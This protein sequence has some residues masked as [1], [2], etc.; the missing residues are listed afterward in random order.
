MGQYEWKMWAILLILII[1][2]ATIIY[3]IYTMQ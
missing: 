1:A 2:E 3:N